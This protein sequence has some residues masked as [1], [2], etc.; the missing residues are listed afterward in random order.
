MDISGGTKQDIIATRFSNGLPA[1]SED[2]MTAWMEYAYQQQI[3]PTNATG[4]PVI[5]SVVDP[6]G[7]YYD[8]GITTSDA[9]GAFKIANSLRKYQANTL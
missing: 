4:V 5:V 1:V 2:S 8:V 6:N 3:K 7:N 9:T